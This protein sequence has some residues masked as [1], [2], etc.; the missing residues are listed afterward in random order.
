MS[1]GS[2]CPIS[3]AC[4]PSDPQTTGPIRW[5]SLGPTIAAPAP[6]AKRNAVERSAL[7][8]MSVNRST[9]MINTYFEAPL[10]MNESAIAVA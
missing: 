8:V 9:P 10:R 6:S 5:V 1:H 2:V 3:G 7:F 4:S